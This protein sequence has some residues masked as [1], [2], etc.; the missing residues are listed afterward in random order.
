MRVLLIYPKSP[1]SFWSFDEVNRL[2]GAKAL[3]PPVGLLTVAAYL[4]PSW[5]LRVVDENVRPLTDA[6]WNFAEAVLV[7]GMLVQQDAILATVREAKRRGKFVVVGG[8]YASSMPELPLQAGADCVVAGEIEADPELLPAILQEA[9][10]CGVRHIEAKPDVA[11]S[12]PPRYDLLHDL[13]DYNT[14]C[15]QTSR[16]CPHDCE[17]CDIV[18]LYGKRPR[19]KTPEQV[20]AELQN[21]YDLGWRGD[22]FFT[23]DNLIGNK[24]HARTLLQAII[25]WMA[26]HGEPFGFWAQTSVDLGH[27][28]E[29]IDLLT[30]A[31][32]STVFL[33]VETPDEEALKRSHKLQN[34][35]APLAD[36]LR[37]ITR[38]GLLTMNS[39]IL[40]F[41][42]EKPGA[43]ERI[44]AFV[45]GLGAMH[46]MVNIMHALPNTRLWDRLESEGRLRPEHT[47]GDTFS[48]PLNFIPDRDEQELLHEGFA[49]WR[50][51][52][53]PR[54]VLARARETFHLMRPTRAAMGDAAPPLQVEVSHIPTVSGS[55]PWR[56][57]F[58]DL[59]GGA[60]LFWIWGFSP[61]HRGARL[62][63]WRTLLEVQRR[64]PTRVKKLLAAL[65]LSHNTRCYIDA[66]EER[67][68]GQGG[69]TTASQDRPLPVDGE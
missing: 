24:R 53:A 55:R 11:L 40:G 42:G 22:V 67:I 64:N 51:L 49:V 57:T 38:G 32:V 15:L 52:Y 26:A 66:L 23:D 36:S 31:N 14:M 41:D 48:A 19:Y 5:P 62:T 68:V 28:Q 35:K 12:P 54:N 37:A 7:S 10:P 44:A 60:R 6:D 56:N 46:V 59:K 4:P 25:P 2:A 27:D 16:G 47:R 18:A 61:A 13:N 65:A 30:Q 17:F 39:F 58:R 33:G 3:V 43:G 34:V 20:L 69:P 45:E 8:P 1:Y 9:V 63:F 21:L 50:R 29:L